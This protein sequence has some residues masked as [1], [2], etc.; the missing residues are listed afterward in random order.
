MAPTLTTD[1]SMPID[2]TDAKRSEGGDPPG[3]EDHDKKMAA[4]PITPAGVPPQFDGNQDI[5]AGSEIRGVMMGTQEVTTG[6]G[7]SFGRS[8]DERERRAGD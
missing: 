8:R 6:S 2:A 4:A 5:L 3:G 7:A 1:N